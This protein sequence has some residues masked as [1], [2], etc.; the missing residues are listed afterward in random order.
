MQAVRASDSVDFLFTLVCTM[1]I[2]VF[3]IKM[4]NLYFCVSFQAARI[5]L[6]MARVHLQVARVY[7]LVGYYACPLPHAQVSAAGI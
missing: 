7:L 5:H 1:I 6:Q 4:L 3:I 2:A